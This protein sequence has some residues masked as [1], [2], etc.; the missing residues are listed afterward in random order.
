[1]FLSHSVRSSPQLLAI[2]A[3]YARINF[4]FASS[5]SGLAAY[6]LLAVSRFWRRA[7]HGVS[8][9]S[10]VLV[11]SGVSG[12]SGVFGQF[13]SWYFFKYLLKASAIALLGSVVLVD[14]SG[15]R[16]ELLI[17]CTS[18]SAIESCS[19]STSVAVSILIELISLTVGRLSVVDCWAD[20]TTRTLWPE[21]S[22]PLTEQSLSLQVGSLSL[23][24]F[25]S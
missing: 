1:M 23:S 9:V 4:L 3:S 13:L 14:C 6:S 7:S 20:G 21:F 17:D 2:A 10:G 5:L 22:N 19:D 12:F 11:V 18:K 8:G 25:S 24:I 15:I 16:N